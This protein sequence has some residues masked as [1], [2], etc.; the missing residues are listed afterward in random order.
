[1]DAQGRLPLYQF[2]FVQLLFKTVYLLFHLGN[3]CHLLMRFVNLYYS[4]HSWTQA[5]KQ[6]RLIKIGRTQLKISEWQL[7]NCCF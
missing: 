2:G 4:E 7:N 5:S 6:N 1:M 3:W